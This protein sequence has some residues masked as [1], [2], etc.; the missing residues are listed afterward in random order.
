LPPHRPFWAVWW[1]PNHLRKYRLGARTDDAATAA[2]Q[3]QAADKAWSI[4]LDPAATSLRTIP[5][6]LYATLAPGEQ[7]AIRQA[8]GANARMEDPAPDPALYLAL[9]DKA[10]RGVLTIDDVRHALGAPAT[11]TMAAGRSLAARC[12]PENL[13]FR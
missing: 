12:P 8:I 10:A 3:K 2:A 5:P 6:M 13:I 9:S 11:R 1:T 4:A 7:D